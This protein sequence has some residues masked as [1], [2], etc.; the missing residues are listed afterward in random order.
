LFALEKVSFQHSGHGLDA[1]LP[2]GDFEGSAGGGDDMEMFL[3]LFDAFLGSSAT[4]LP[5]T[6]GAGEQF[7][8]HGTS[9]GLGNTAPQQRSE[10]DPASSRRRITAVASA[11]HAEAK[12][13]ILAVAATDTEAATN[14]LAFCAFDSQKKQ[15]TLAHAPHGEDKR[16][17]SEGEGRGGRA[18]AN[19]WHVISWK[20]GGLHSIAGLSFSQSGAKLLVR[21]LKGLYVFDMAPT[22]HTL[23]GATASE[24]DREKKEKEEEEEKQKQEENEAQ[25][26]KSL[27]QQKTKQHAT[28]SWA[29]TGNSKNTSQG[30][31]SNGTAAS[32]G[33]HSSSK[34]NSAEST[35]GINH[36]H[37][38]GAMGL[39][40]QVACLVENA[41]SKLVASLCWTRSGDQRE[42]ACAVTREGEVM[43]YE[44]ESKAELCRCN[45]DDCSDL[46]GGNFTIR[47]VFLIKAHS[48][49]S[50]L[51]CTTPEGGGPFFTLLLECK[52]PEGSFG[53]Y[54]A[55]PE[56]AI[57][58][59]FQLKSL[60]NKFGITSSNRSSGVRLSAQHI[61]NQTAILSSHDTVLNRLELYDVDRPDDPVFVHHLPPAT[62]HVSMT[63][64]LIFAVHGPHLIK[65]VAASEEEEPNND[66]KQAGDLRDLFSSSSWYGVDDFNNLLQPFAG[67]G[68]SK[69]HYFVSIISRF[70]ADPDKGKRKGGKAMNLLLQQITF[71]GTPPRKPLGVLT[72]DSFSL[73][74]RLVDKKKQGTETVLIWTDESLFACYLSQNPESLFHQLLPGK[75]DNNNNS[76][77][78]VDTKAELL[79][80]SLRLDI[81]KLYKQA[82]S[83][84]LVQKEFD[85][86]QSYFGLAGISEIEGACEL[87]AAQYPE[88]ALQIMKN[89][90]QN[91]HV[92]ATKT[93]VLKHAAIAMKLM[94]RLAG[95]SANVASDA[96]NAAAT[97]IADWARCGGFVGGEKSFRLM[98]SA[99]IL[100][101]IVFNKACRNAGESQ[102][103]SKSNDDIQEE[104]EEMEKEEEEEGAVE[105][106]IEEIHDYDFDHMLDS[107]MKTGAVSNLPFVTEEDL[108][109]LLTRDITASET[110]SF[111][112]GLGSCERTA[113]ALFAMQASNKQNREDHSKLQA[114]LQRLLRENVSFLDKAWALSSCIAWN[115]SAAAGALLGAVGSD[116]VGAM[117]CV[118]SD[119]SRKRRRGEMDEREHCEQ[120]VE[121]VRTCVGT[122]TTPEKQWSEKQLIATFALIFAHWA[123][124]SQDSLVLEESLESILESVESGKLAHL[125]LRADLLVNNRAFFSGKFYIKLAAYSTNYLLHFKT[126]SS[127]LKRIKGSPCL[128]KVF[129]IN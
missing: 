60:E 36:N 4:S 64:T 82:A 124:F 118:L 108:V 51:L 76:K 8:Y 16:D 19:Q 120:I 31:N 14:Y 23:F 102:S 65:H 24:G 105:S 75:S 38:G 50:L 88:R 48:S 37:S 77:E 72:L 93:R 126:S 78:S 54:E 18:A 116:I 33:D 22:A 42:V 39:S 41:S 21:S 71:P 68:E 106:V 81:L 66:K 69:S 15:T 59:D 128:P 92:D 34:N 123:D 79:A 129:H 103:E 11:Y 109:N 32:D 74:G 122:T 63:D 98:V 125:L 45:F 17:A 119:I 47:K 117:V 30:Q 20:K 97:T 40:Q 2:G 110:T 127:V 5:Q 107:M 89:L 91:S 121:L 83:T 46:S 28:W 114:D 43:M 10:F 84:A 1:S 80:L 55:L 101:Q 96:A 73:S 26:E 86:A 29:W 100:A 56:A 85:L 53:G 70:I 35:N 90:D 58:K 25:T 52:D 115:N 87:L 112:E 67:Q 44:L 12:G 27:S 99:A 57:L 7:N 49:Q 61:Y 113:S 111:E 94:Q 9:R 104:E 95:M 3:D 62:L 13:D 6:S